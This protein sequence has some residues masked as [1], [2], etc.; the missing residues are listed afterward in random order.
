MI[1]RIYD[2]DGVYLKTT[3]GCEQTIR[4]N[5]PDGGFYEE[6]EAYVEPVLAVL[7]PVTDLFE[8]L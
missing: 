5:T 3:D 6:I 7:V 4:I 8:G 2:M 1:A